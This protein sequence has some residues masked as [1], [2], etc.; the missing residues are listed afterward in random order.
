MRGVWWSVGRVNNLE[1][2]LEVVFVILMYIPMINVQVWRV[3]FTLSQ[4]LHGIF[5]EDTLEDSVNMSRLTTPMTM[6]LF[7]EYDSR[8]SSE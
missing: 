4:L 5:R 1:V 7:G 6:Q 3:I 2:R 8:C